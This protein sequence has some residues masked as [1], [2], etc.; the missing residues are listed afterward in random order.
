MGVPTAEV[1]Y[2]S[3]TTGRW[4]HQVHNAHVV[5]L[6]QINLIDY[7]V[8]SNGKKYETLRNVRL[9]PQSKREMRSAGVSNRNYE[10]VVPNYTLR[11]SPEERSS[12][13]ETLTSLNAVCY[14]KYVSMIHLYTVLH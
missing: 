12:Q 3:A 10:Y 1:G 9:P 14:R 5:A 13:S 2:T 8:L 6:T 11:N 4:D 7:S